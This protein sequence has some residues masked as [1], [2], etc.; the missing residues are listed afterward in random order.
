MKK[1]NP[2]YANKQRNGRRFGLLIVPLLIFA[3]GPLGSLIAQSC[4]HSAPIERELLSNC[5]PADP[6]EDGGCVE[7]IWEDDSGNAFPGGCG[8]YLWRHCA[9]HSS[10]PAQ[11]V[12]QTTRLMICDL[13]GTACGAVYSTTTT[14]YNAPPNAWSSCQP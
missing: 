6:Y 9:P 12:T 13:W 5:P 1:N 10:L 2:L 14:T 11:T 8:P 3:A 4:N 7:T